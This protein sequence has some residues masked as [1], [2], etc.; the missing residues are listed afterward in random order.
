MKYEYVFSLIK[1][2][3]WIVFYFL[4]LT[5]FLLFVHTRG[6]VLYD[7]GYILNSAL[8]TINGEVPYKD[9]HFVYTP[10]SIYIVL[11]GFF[12]FG[13]SVLAERLI[14]VAFAI[15]TSFLLLM[16][17]RKISK[18]KFYQALTVSF[19]IVWGPLHTNFS[20]PVTYAVFSGILTSYFWLNGVEKQR[21]IFFHLAGTATLL[22][23]LFKQNF[24]FAI[25]ICCLISFIITREIRKVKFIITYFVGFSIPLLIFLLYLFQT[26]AL[27]PFFDDFYIFTIKRIVVDGTLSTSFIYHESP[28]LLFAKFGFYILPVICS[29]YAIFLSFKKKN[30]L[31]FLPI[32]C[33]LYYFF[34]IRP[35]TDYIHVTPL[36]AITSI[37]FVQCV[38]S[39]HNR[40]IK[41]FLFLSMIILIGIG[42]YRGLWNGYYKWEEPLIKSG[43][44]MNNNNIRI[45]VDENKKIF[46]NQYVSYIDSYTKPSDYIFVN[47]YEPFLYFVVNRKNPT[48]FDIVGPNLFYKHYEKEVIFYLI[49]NRVQVIV[50]YTNWKSSFLAEYIKNHYVIDKEIGGYLLW[51]KNDNKISKESESRASIVD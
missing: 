43:S 47:E 36:L 5:I 30:N 14:T 3:K 20:W 10:G 26:K 4:F 49:K 2:N 37:P 45:W 41:K 13:K 22:T 19:Y 7:E 46:I 38:A 8:R 18:N 39:I 31:L 29:C 21:K 15:L 34:G 50:T 32:F 12:L 11:V 33:L 40:R 17:A 1:N 42:F 23:F 6:I 28:V 35:T 48:K 44:F 51:K 27:F 25:I 24:G 9:F 16:I